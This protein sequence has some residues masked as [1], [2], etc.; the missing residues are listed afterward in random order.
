MHKKTEK[1]VSELIVKFDE[2]VAAGDLNEM[3]RIVD[4]VCASPNKPFRK[5]MLARLES[6]RYGD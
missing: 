6:F 4:A 5:A 1:R 2:A 3:N